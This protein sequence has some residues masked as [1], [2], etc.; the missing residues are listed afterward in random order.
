MAGNPRYYEKL[1]LQNK[2]TKEVTIPS[3]SQCSLIGGPLIKDA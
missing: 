2:Y 1:K 3:P